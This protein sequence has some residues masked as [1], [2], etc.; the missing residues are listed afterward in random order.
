MTD[1]GVDI[2]LEDW[3]VFQIADP[4]ITLDTLETIGVPSLKVDVKA[5]LAFELNRQI[6]SSS[7]Q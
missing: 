4:A 7:G 1:T 2:P 6:L 5:R 3:Q